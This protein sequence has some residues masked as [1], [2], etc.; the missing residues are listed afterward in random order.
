MLE[1]D[2]FRRKKGSHGLFEERRR[3][4]EKEKTNHSWSCQGLTVLVIIQQVASPEAHSRKLCTDLELPL[5]PPSALFQ[6]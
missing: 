6:A 3:E 5:Q 1:K 4:G 2:Q